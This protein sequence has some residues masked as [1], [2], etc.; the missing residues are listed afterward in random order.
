MNIPPTEAFANLIRMER[1]AR[2]APIKSQ[3][4]RAML[5]GDP[6]EGLRGAYQ[7]LLD[8]PGTIAWPSPDASLADAIASLVR[9]WP[10][11]FP[12][13]PLW[14]TDPA[15][16]AVLNPPGPA[17]VVACSEPPE[18]WAQRAMAPEHGHRDMEPGDL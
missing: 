17:C 3:L 7:A 6:V 8:L 11:D 12:P 2:L 1:D 5:L 16:A 10:A 13:L 4:E 15:S 18:E 9:Q 14:F